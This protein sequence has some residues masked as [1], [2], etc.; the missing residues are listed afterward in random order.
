MSSEQA[1]FFMDALTNMLMVSTVE[2]SR[3]VQPGGCCEA[4]H[5]RAWGT[6]SGSP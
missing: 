2:S 6:V 1:I 3:F 5:S 4:G